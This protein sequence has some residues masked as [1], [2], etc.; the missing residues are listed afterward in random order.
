MKNGQKILHL[1][2]D[3]KFMDYFIQQSEEVSP[4]S[5]TYWVAQE[6][7]ISDLNRVTSPKA[8]GIQWSKTSLEKLVQEANTYSKIVLHSFFFS[9]LLSFTKKI[10]K[11]IPIVWM[12]WGGDGYTFAM[13]QDRWYLPFTKL[14]KKQKASKNE[15]FVKSL[16]SEFK[17][18][19]LRFKEAITTRRLIMQV[20]VCATWVKFDY[21]M[22]KHIN[23]RMKW[24]YYSYFT[25]SDINFDFIDRLDTTKI[26]E[27]IWLG[28]SATDTNN[29]LDA[30]NY[31]H[32]VG[33]KG[34][35]FVPLSY[36]DAAYRDDIIR[37][38]SDKFGQ[39][40]HPIVEY[41][42]LN[43]YYELMNS[44]AFVWMNHIRQ[45]AAGNTL[46]ALYMKKAVI[47]NEDNNLYKTLKEWGIQF[48]QPQQ[49]N[50]I[51]NFDQNL[52]KKNSEIVKMRLSPK[53]NLEALTAIYND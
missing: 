5:S 29:H 1:M 18:K 26:N 51:V 38:G 27:G 7:L 6:K 31:L 52:Y 11:T 20:D 46:A 21:E 24:R 25:T 44:C 8:I 34:K 10:E 40:F 39:Q 16:Y 13:D 19:Y 32:S 15:N 33:W 42:S 43:R 4:G 48:S 23:P 9:D 35:I 47:M 50:D 2:L 36:G 28:N 37:Y 22:I 49:L 14:Y 53:E 30:L 45:Q 17:L 3:D 12:F 41:L